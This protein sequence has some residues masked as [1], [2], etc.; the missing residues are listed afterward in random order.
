M[1]TRGEAEEL[2]RTLFADPGLARKR[3]EDELV[4]DPDP[5]ISSIGHQVVGIV[6]RELGET[7]AALTELRTSL[8]L[9]RRSG[10]EERRGDALATLGSTLCIAG[11]LPEGMRR[12]DQAASL[13]EGVPL[14]R[15]LVL[16]LIHI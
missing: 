8:A 13:L 5:V 9:A 3:A 10:D 4:A 11:W 7:D 16:S 14:G 6:L 12:L 15:A 2:L 1:M